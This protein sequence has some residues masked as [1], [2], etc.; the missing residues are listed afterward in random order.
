MAVAEGRG[1]VLEDA[2]AVSGDASPTAC[3]FGVTKVMVWLAGVTAKLWLALGAALKFAF[4]ACAAWIVQVPPALT[5]TVVPLI[6]Q[7]AVVSD[8]NVTTNP[9]D[10]VAL[11]VNGAAP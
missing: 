7:T 3:S 10:A 1:S 2:V 4:P 9:D 5:V 11:T 8:E 6:V